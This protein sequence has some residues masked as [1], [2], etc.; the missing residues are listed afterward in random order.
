M[1]NIHI[2]GTLYPLWLLNICYIFL[3]AL[4]LWGTRPV[5]HPPHQHSRTEVLQLA[6][7]LALPSSHT[8]TAWAPSFIQP[9]CTCCQPQILGR[10]TNICY[11]QNMFH[12]TSFT[13]NKT[14]IHLVQRGLGRHQPVTAHSVGAE[15]A[16]HITTCWKL[17]D[18]PFMVSLQLCYLISYTANF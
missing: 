1:L 8:T 2:F 6:V 3:Q 11:K 9:C 17:R 7:G 12:D 4:S 16:C 18:M 10:R 15:V 5:P 14:N 13:C